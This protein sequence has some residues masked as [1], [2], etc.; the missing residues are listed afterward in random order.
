MA[1]LVIDPPFIQEMPLQEALETITKKIRETHGTA[2]RVTYQGQNSQRAQ[3]IGNVEKPLSPQLRPVPLKTL[4]QYLAAQSNTKISLES[5]LQSG[6]IKVDYAAEPEEPRQEVSDEEIRRRIEKFKNITIE[7]YS[8]EDMPLSEAIFGALNE[9][10]K[11]Q[12]ENTISMVIRNGDESGSM[13]KV[14]YNCKNCRVDDI[15]TALRE[16]AGVYLEFKSHALVLDLQEGV[17]TSS[18]E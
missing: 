13:P 11:R 8:V 12:K 14:T 5:G 6:L 15:I 9:Q 1:E 7:E 17:G 18:P 16:Q 2:I 4:L 10:L 3:R